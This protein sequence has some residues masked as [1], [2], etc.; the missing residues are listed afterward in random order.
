[1]DN[2]GKTR[3][4]F[5]P[6]CGNRTDEDDHFCRWCG[7]TADRGD[8][9]HE[10]VV[11]GGD[12]A[13][14]GAAENAAGAK[15]GGHAPHKGNGHT[16]SRGDGPNSSNSTHATVVGIPIPVPGPASAQGGEPAGRMRRVRTALS[17]NPRRV[18]VGCGVAAALVLGIVGYV[19]LAGPGS[20][21]DRARVSL[22]SGRTAVV[23]ATTAA[24]SAR[25]LADVRDAGGTARDGIGRVSAELTAVSGIDDA[26]YRE[27]A[28]A[29]LTA[30]R[31]YLTELSKLSALKDSN[32]KDWTD[33]QAALRRTTLEIVQAEPGVKALDLGSGR[34]LVPSSAA[35][36]RSVT[37]VDTLVVSAKRRLARWHHRLAKAQGKRKRDLTVITQYSSTMRGYVGRYTQLRTGMASWIDEVDSGGVT[38]A[39]AYQFLGDARGSRD[40]LKSTISNLAAPAVAAAAQS[41]IEQVLGESVQAMDDAITG[42]SDYQFDEA[43]F[44]SYKDTPGWQSFASSSDR[45]SGEYASATANWSKVVDDRANAV[46][47]RHLPKRPDV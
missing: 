46:K 24:Q 7:H 18:L 19:L 1:M 11:V 9:T 25:R 31:S 41:R 45:I 10:L 34:S 13:R 37:A 23:A 28:T 38:Y 40:S 30:E 6:E 20:A 14:G 36:N 16:P 3:G 2:I 42:V 33:I 27:A 15:V 44:L 43:S 29:A 8:S 21:P 4:L 12:A 17:R 32:L 35:I 26:H 22:T 5:C 47:H 39:E